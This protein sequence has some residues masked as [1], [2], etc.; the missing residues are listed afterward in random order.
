[1]KKVDGINKK[2]E[3]IAGKVL[4][5]IGKKKDFVH[6]NEAGFTEDTREEKRN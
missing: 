5:A 3:E 2:K 6:S 1:V 4:D